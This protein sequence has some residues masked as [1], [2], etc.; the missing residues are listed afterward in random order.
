MFCF[1][2][3]FCCVRPPGH[4]ATRSQSGGFCF[5]NNAAIAAKYAQA[6]YGVERVAV[7]DFDV[8]HGNGTEEGFEP[9]DNLFY[10][11]THEKDNYPG[12]GRDPSPNIGDKAVREVDRRIVNRTLVAR[13]FMGRLGS[14]SS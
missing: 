10:G 2:N 3:V 14:V 8:H 7:L 4:H 11:S 6:Y 5:F 9:Y 13:N 1:R 12:T